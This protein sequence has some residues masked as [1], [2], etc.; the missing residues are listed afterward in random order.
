MPLFLKS[1]TLW[2]HY[3]RHD[4]REQPFSTGP[5]FFLRWTRQQARLGLTAALFLASEDAILTRVQPPLVAKALVNI[6]H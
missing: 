4:V 2:V 6:G 5:L 3:H 1:C